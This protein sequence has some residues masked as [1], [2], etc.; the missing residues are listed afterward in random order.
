MRSFLPGLVTIPTSFCRQRKAL[1]ATQVWRERELAEIEQLNL[2]SVDAARYTCQTGLVASTSYAATIQL[3]V[4]EVIVI[5][6]RTQ[7]G[8]NAVSPVEITLQFYKEHQTR[9]AVWMPFKGRTRHRSKPVRCSAKT[10]H[11]AGCRYRFSQ[12][13]RL[14]SL[15]LSTNPTVL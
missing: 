3:I 1:P 8:N 10:L 4:T 9:N 15:R 2:V 13:N 6:G 12:W 14:W 11:A 7:K 5:V